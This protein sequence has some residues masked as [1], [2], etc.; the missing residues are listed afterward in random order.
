EIKTGVKRDGTLTALDARIIFDGGA[1][2]GGPIPIAALLLAAYY[3]FQNFD[4]RAYDV[5]THKPGVGAYRA[6]GA[7]QASFAIES[8]MDE[9]ARAIGLDPLDLRL[10]NAV[11]EGDSMPNGRPWPKIGLR[12]CLERLRDERA[13]RRGVSARSNGARHG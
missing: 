6:P 11:T 5:L 12:E 9:M 13:R 7:V 10:Q 4:V 2:G 1:S 3:R 8:Q